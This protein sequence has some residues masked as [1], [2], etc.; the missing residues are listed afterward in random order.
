MAAELDAAG[1]ERLATARAATS[2]DDLGRPSR[3]EWRGQASGPTRLSPSEKAE[4]Y[5]AADPDAVRAE[6]DGGGAVSAAS[7]ITL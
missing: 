1:G 5:A 4:R 3:R 2:D 6:V 7:T